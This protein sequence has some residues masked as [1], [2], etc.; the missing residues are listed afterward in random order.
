MTDQ[1]SVCP[2]CFEYLDPEDQLLERR[3]FEVCNHC[4]T[5]YHRVC[6]EK[7]NRC[8]HCKHN[9]S[10]ATQPSALI[11][12]PLETKM[13]AISIAPSKIAFVFGNQEIIVPEVVYTDL[14]PLY[15]DVL[16]PRIQQLGIME[17]VPEEL[18]GSIGVIVGMLLMTVAICLSCSLCVWIL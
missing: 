3:T 8:L 10:Q 16:N 11:P 6:W 5:I 2:Y 9:Q 17:Y 4:D 7:D 13:D 12:I 18:R 15:Q 1:Q 14:I